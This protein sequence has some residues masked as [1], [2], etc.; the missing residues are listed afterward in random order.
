MTRLAPSSS[1]PLPPLVFKKTKEDLAARFW[2]AGDA[3]KAREGSWR[4]SKAMDK[5]ANKLGQVARTVEERKSLRGS[6]LLLPWSSPPLPSS[7]LLAVEEES[8][9]TRN[10]GARIAAH[11]MMAGAVRSPVKE[12]SSASPV[13][14]AARTLNRRRAA[15]PTKLTQKR[16]L[17]DDDEEAWLLPSP[18]SPSPSLPP[19]LPPTPLSFSSPLP[20]APA[21]AAP[22]SPPLPSR[23]RPPLRLP[24]LQ[25][26][27]KWST[28]G[29]AASAMQAGGTR[30]E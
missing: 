27:S 15:H 9:A 7:T 3:S 16:G 5:R 30:T 14:S 1:S 2:T 11:P 6:A 19:L 18:T 8:K 24:R 25:R 22:A 29:L 23:L 21:S 13:L 17:A 12:E 26:R 20:A 28:T 4:A 10:A